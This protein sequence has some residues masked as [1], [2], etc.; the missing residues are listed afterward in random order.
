MVG[1]YRDQEATDRVIRD[2]WFHT[3]DLGRLDEEGN[4]YICGRIKDMIVTHGGKKVF[5]EDIESYYSQIDKVQEICVVGIDKN[6]GMGEEPGALIVPF[7]PKVREEG[8]R[9]KVETEIR[10][11]SKALSAKLPD[12]KRLKKVIFRTSGLPKTTTMKVRRFLVK[13]SIVEGLSRDKSSR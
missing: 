10:R 11:E 3:G 2:G 6:G 4:L 9:A 13:E 5:P 12:Y 1:Y 7:E 8:G